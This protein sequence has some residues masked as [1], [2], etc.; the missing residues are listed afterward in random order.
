ME[1]IFCKF[2]N[3]SRANFCMNCGSP[4]NLKV[5]SDCG[6]M[7]EKNAN[8]CVGCKAPLMQTTIPESSIVEET[9]EIIDIVSEAE[10]LAKEATKFK[11]FITELQINTE[12]VAKAIQEEET[13]EV[14]TIEKLLKEKREVKQTEIAVTNNSTDAERIKIEIQRTR[15][16][17]Y[18]SF[19]ILLILA[20]G[21]GY[22][23]NSRNSLF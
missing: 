4:Q 23:L 17:G 2:E 22:Y 14:V 9:S 10:A 8:Q 15:H 21:I 12:E 13:S 5:C 6:A 1:C 19:T 7:N 3:P 18:F 11:Q 20:C 16:W